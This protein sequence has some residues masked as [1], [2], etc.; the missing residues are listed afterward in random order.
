MKT[1]K[2]YSRFFIIQLFVLLLGS[3][4]MMAQ[5]FPSCP[6]SNTNQMKHQHGFNF[7]R[8]GGKFSPEEYQEIMQKYIIKEAKLSPTEA[9]IF[10]PL[11]NEL[12]EK[13]RKIFLEINKM[14][15][16]CHRHKD[17]SEKE[18]QNILNEIDKKEMER[19]LLI[20]EYHKKWV[21]AISAKKVA[22]VLLAEKTFG[23][24]TLTE[25]T[26]GRF[27]VLDDNKPKK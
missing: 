13:E 18:A 7:V 16:S 20:Q 25:F 27:K 1:E 14:I 8:F 4:T 19:T 22:N 23:R 21:K 9:T 24:R 17:M 10:F 5:P 15:L 12:H 26:K 6:Q 11:F 3:T 2:K